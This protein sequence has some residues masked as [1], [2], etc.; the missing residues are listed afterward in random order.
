MTS[1]PVLVNIDRS[2]IE[3]VILDKW[4]HSRSC[5]GRVGIV[6]KRVKGGPGTRIST[7]DL[8]VRWPALQMIGANDRLFWGE[9]LHVGFVGRDV[10]EECRRLAAISSS[11]EL[12]PPFL[13]RRAIARIGNY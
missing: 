9:V 5:E 11:T 2:A 7:N 8:I 1:G 13:R 3:C 12:E 6:R 10:A 4:D